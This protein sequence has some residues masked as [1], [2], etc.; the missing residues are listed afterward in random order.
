MPR[1]SFSRESGAPTL[2]RRLGPWLGLVALCLALYLPGLATLPP[3]DRDEARF[4][5]ATRQMLETGDYVRIR[6]QDEA[7]NKKPVGIYWAQ[8]V[9]AEAFGGAAAPIW[10]FRLPSLVALIG[11]VLLLYAAGG[12]L[13]EPRTA[14]VG[15]S[16]LAACLL[17]TVEAHLAKTDAA[18]LA[19][20]VAAQGA[21]AVLYL[22]GRD[23]LPA[24]WAAPIGFWVAI[25]VGILLK[26][27]VLPA[28]SLL[29]VA[30]L[31]VA[32]RSLAWLKGLRPALGILIAAA[33]VA[34]WG[35]AIT[36]A[37]G[38]AFVADA[39]S[40]DLIPKLLGGQES[41]GAPP[42]TYL[43]LLALGFFPASLQVAPALR[44]AWRRRLL[45]AERF[46]LAWLV[47][48]WLALEL[49]PTKLPHYVLP[50][51]PAL[52]L[53]TARFVIGDGAPSASTRPPRWV[54]AL[55]ALWLV[56]ALALV[57]AVIALPVVI[58]RHLDWLGLVPALVAG[59]GVIAACVAAWGGQALRGVVIGV[60]S[61]GVLYA[62][63]FGT[64][65]P[66]L[67]GL[68]LSRSAA[69]MVAAYRPG[70][71][72][73]VVAAGYAEPSLVFLLGTATQLTGGAGAADALAAQPGALAL[74]AADQDANFR[75]RAA[76]LGIAVEAL[77]RRTGYNY[78]HGRWTTLAL[79]RRAP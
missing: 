26:G 40:N 11:A 52:A 77:D 16:L 71:H 75:A 53:L 25:G 67:D 28:V 6:F 36:R 14:F 19:A 34:P 13:F 9:A 65:L 31:A 61:A 66:R 72:T 68:W 73:P 21:L 2:T 63:A 4:A 70:D 29:T 39:V 59:A 30:A 62:T 12:R 69:A 42:G 23:G 33:I 60:A 64:V 15:A 43:A 46:C 1:R 20:T 3:T 27:P 48:A 50:L 47:P 7:R 41:H 38:G 76:A 74:V 58:D 37:T 44:D 35:I 8:A 57:G 78:S 18:L 54:R 5:Q 49:V 32:D 55:F 79:Y 17:A 45:P 51:Y 24:G 10:A 56:A 22:R